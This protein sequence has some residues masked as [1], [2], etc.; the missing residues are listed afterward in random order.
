VR[1]YDIWHGAKGEHDPL[2]VSGEIFIFGWAQEAADGHAE[3]IGDVFQVLQIRLGI[4]H[5][6]EQVRDPRLRSLIAVV[7]QR[8][9]RRFVDASVLPFLQQRA[10]IALE[11]LRGGQLHG[12]HCRR[13]FTSCE[14]KVRRVN[15]LEKCENISSMFVDFD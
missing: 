12:L 8:A 15:H 4:P 14:A 7:G 6:V 9:V 11:S 5:F 13:F 10:Q 2:F 1:L 3:E